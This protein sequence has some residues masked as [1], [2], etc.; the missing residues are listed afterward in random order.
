MEFVSPRKLQHVR[1][2]VIASFMPRAAEFGRT[3]RSVYV[4]RVAAPPL[5]STSQTIV[6]VAEGKH[7]P[8]PLVFSEGASR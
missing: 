3:H 8:M 1:H 2:D 5:P 6:S 4:F 7:E